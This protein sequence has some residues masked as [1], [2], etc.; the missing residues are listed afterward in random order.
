MLLELAKVRM[1]CDHL[2][3]DIDCENSAPVAGK[4]S[5][6]MR[7]KGIGT[8]S[9]CAAQQF[10]FGEHEKLFGS[11]LSS[12]GRTGQDKI[13]MQEVSLFTSIVGHFWQF[14]VDVEGRSC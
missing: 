1:I 12:H 11:K 5:V 8:V 4:L 13:P 3:R 14:V 9:S 7:T 2:M 10:S 6:A